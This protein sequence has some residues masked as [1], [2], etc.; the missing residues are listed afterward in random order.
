MQVHDFAKDDWLL[1]TTRIWV[2]S[3]YGNS[4]LQ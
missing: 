2:E 3:T 1:F 4:Y